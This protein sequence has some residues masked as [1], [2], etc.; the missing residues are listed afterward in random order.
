MS[1]DAARAFYEKIKSDAAL[2][3]EVARL[4]EDASDADL[5]RVAGEAGFTC[6]ADDLNQVGHEVANELNDDQLDA[7]A[8]GTGP[9]A[10]Q[11][12]NSALKATPN[13][14]G[15]ASSL[16]IMPGTPGSR[17]I[18]IGAFKATSS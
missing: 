17:A 3:K 4:G 7:V 16:K 12:G 15:G 6:T 13:T 1:K 9:V 18:L 14:P 5:I 10:P 8:G 11:P 2:A